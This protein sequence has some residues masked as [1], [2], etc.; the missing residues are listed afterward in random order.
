M[1]TRR[2]TIAVESP[3]RPRPV[4]TGKPSINAASSIDTEKR[5][6]ASEHSRMDAESSSNN[7]QESSI[8]RITS[9]HQSPSSTVISTSTSSRASSD[10]PDGNKHEAPT[11][12]I[13]EVDE[14]LTTNVGS[15]S[16]D[17]TMVT[18]TREDWSPTLSVAGVGDAE[19]L[20]EVDENFPVNRQY[21]G[22]SSPTVSEM[23]KSF[24][25]TRLPSP[26]D[27]EMEQAE[28]GTSGTL[29]PSGDV[30]SLFWDE[31][32]AVH[33]DRFY[34]SPPKK[35][36]GKQKLAPVIPEDISVGPDED[37]QQAELQE[38][39]DTVPESALERTS[40]SICSRLSQIYA[41]FLITSNTTGHTSSP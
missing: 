9:T 37:Q 41:L 1:R 33:P 14:L 34:Q 6:S 16:I 22:G 5:F 36:Y 18:V 11:S 2:N 31:G 20:M 17:G 15:C 28:V 24:V 32:D 30:H 7:G 3:L 19:D 13:D 23:A 35:V 10:P 39:E 25:P 4:D 27:A 38:E 40:V 26:H 21:P 29:D 12:E 8:H